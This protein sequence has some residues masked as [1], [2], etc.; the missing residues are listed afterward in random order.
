MTTEQPSGP[1]PTSRPE[2]SS[3]PEPPARTRTSA[4]WVA[5]V[6]TLVIL[7]VLIVFILENGQHVKVSF[8]GAHGHLPLGV[9]LLAA[10]V[11]GGLFVVL[12]GAA[13]IVQLRLRHR[14]SRRAAQGA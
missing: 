12:V 6:A 11:V 14:R 2:A 13:R 8:F 3:A 1:A 7:A 4:L 5:I 10:A 9:A